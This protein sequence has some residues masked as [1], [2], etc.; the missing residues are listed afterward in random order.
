MHGNRLYLELSDYKNNDLLRD[1][2]NRINANMRPMPF[3]ID[4][5]ARKVWFYP[6]ESY[7]MPQLAEK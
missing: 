4:Y 7:V 2:V 5:T 1:Y 3:N 6:P